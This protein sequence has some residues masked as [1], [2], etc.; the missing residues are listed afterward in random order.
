MKGGGP[1]ATGVGVVRE[2][3]NHREVA[4]FENATVAEA[5]GR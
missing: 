4:D 1:S 3:V 5:Q 2:R